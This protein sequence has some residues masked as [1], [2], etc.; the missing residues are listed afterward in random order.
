MNFNNNNILIGIGVV[1]A[2]IILGAGG[3]F[4]FQSQK[5]Q[6][7]PNNPQA[8]QE[9]NRKLIAEIGKLIDLPIGEE[10]TVA[11]VTDVAKLQ[12]QP[13]FQKAKNGDVVLIYA[14]SRK[15]ILYDPSAKKIID[16]A[17]LNI[18]SPSAELAS[19]SASPQL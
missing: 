10:P 18:G 4:Y 2:I 19:P 14:N 6:V 3:F 16:V 17:P 11:T 8:V 1:A 5:T 13:F 7:D 15:A 12:N 9:Q